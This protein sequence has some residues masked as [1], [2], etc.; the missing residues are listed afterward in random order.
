[1][2]HAAPA[3]QAEPYAL[4]TLH[5]GIAYERAALAWFD[6][7]PAAIRGPGAWRDTGERR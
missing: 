4:A 7:P 3:D 1:M 5:F 2:Q 6:E